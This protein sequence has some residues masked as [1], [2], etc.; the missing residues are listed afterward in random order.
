MADLVQ[1][2]AAPSELTGLAP[3][4]DAALDDAVTCARGLRAG[5]G[6]G[7]WNEQALALGALSRL[8]T[9]LVAARAIAR[10]DA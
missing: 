3:P 2:V 8:C 1:L 9:R 10:R 5:R 6:W 4:L 7:Y